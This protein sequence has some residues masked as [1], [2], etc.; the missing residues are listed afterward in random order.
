MRLRDAGRLVYALDVVLVEEQVCA[1]WL[2]LL[3]LVMYIDRVEVA[4][5][6]L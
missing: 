2:C 1:T 4:F 3:A 6:A 5:R